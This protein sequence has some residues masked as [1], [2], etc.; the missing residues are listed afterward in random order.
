MNNMEQIDLNNVPPELLAQVRHDRLE[1]ARLE[2]LRSGRGVYVVK[3][4][5]EINYSHEYTIKVMARSQGEAE[6]FAKAEY[7]DME[8][9]DFLSGEEIE[10][11]IN[12]VSCTV[13][14][15]P[16]SVLPAEEYYQ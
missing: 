13:E 14:P 8:W 5:A 4:T 16:D 9:D 3:L 1:A 2:E 10:I 11:N 12:D 6:E 7:G 15:D